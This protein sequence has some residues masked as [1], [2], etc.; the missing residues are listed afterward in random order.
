MEYR[1]REQLA[2]LGD[3]HE[4]AIAQP[5]TRKERLERWAHQ[6][7]LQPQRQLTTL[8]ET[9]NRYSAER[10][11]MRADNSPLSVALADPV[12]RAEG[13]RGDSYGEAKR[14]FQLTDDELHDIVCYCHFGASVKARAAATRIQ[15]TANHVPRQGILSTLRSFFAG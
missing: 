6:L 15:K 12:L 8:V 11:K 7:L 4:T 5:M 13:L 9:E 3:L 14:F 10:E 1:T 2:G